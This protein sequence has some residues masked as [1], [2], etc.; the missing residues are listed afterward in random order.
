MLGRSLDDPAKMYLQDVYTVCAN[1][2]GLPALSMPCGFHADGMPIGAQLVGPA[3][4]ENRVLGA[5]HAFQ[6]ETDF[7][8]KHPAC[9]GKGGGGG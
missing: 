7:H 6:L 8:K 9:F 3:F 1:L 4:G 2:A 5:A